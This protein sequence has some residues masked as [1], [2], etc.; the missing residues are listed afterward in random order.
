MHETAEEQHALVGLVNRLTNRL[1]LQDNFLELVYIYC[2]PRT[3][4]HLKV[5]QLLSYDAQVLQCVP[6]ELFREHAARVS[7][8]RPHRCCLPT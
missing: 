5:M 2:E 6:V 3:E 7:T 1:H 4:P 8:H